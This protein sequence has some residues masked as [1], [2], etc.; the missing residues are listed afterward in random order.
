[1]FYIFGD[2]SHCGVCNIYMGLIQTHIDIAYTFSYTSKTGRD[3]KRTTV[4]P[5]QCH[6]KHGSI[7][8]LQ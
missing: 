7:T 5:T 4:L 3:V 2:F 1:M 6:Q 8:I